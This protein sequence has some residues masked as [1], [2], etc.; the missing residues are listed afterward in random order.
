MSV[1]IATVRS[2]TGEAVAR[3]EA[4]W[5]EPALAITLVLAADADTAVRQ[6]LAPIQHGAFRLLIDGRLSFERRAG[7]GPSDLQAVDEFVAN[8]SSGALRL[9]YDPSAVEQAHQWKRQL[10][11][12]EPFS[13]PFSELQEI[14]DRSRQEST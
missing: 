12:G 11:Q 2:Q 4:H 14:L 6:W 5:D 13:V 8:A 3:F 7:Q 1:V 9:E 10:A